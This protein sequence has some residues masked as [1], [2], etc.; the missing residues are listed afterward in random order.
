MNAIPEKDVRDS[1]GRKPRLFSA[2]RPGASALGY[3]RSRDP[4]DGLTDFQT[5]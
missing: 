2:I 1:R 3:Y 4:S 5:C